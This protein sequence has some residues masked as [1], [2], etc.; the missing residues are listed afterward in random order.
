MIACS[1]CCKM[2]SFQ[3]EMLGQMNYIV[4]ANEKLD[5]KFAVLT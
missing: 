4:I 2:L 3:L 5:M 1:E